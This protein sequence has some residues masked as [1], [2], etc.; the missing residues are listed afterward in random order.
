M[1]YSDFTRMLRYEMTGQVTFWDGQSYDTK[2]SIYK[3][4]K[5]WRRHPECVEESQIS[6]DL[7]DGGDFLDIGAFRGYY[8]ALLAPKAKPGTHF[9][10]VEPDPKALPKLAGN[11][12]GLAKTFPHIKFSVINTACGIGRVVSVTDQNGHPCYASADEEEQGVLAATVDSLCLGLGLSPSFVKVDVEGAESAVL[13]G[14]QKTLLEAEKWM[15]EIHPDWLPEGVN[16]ADVEA[17]FTANGYTQKHIQNRGDQPLIW[18][19]K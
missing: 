10:S 17:L 1:R 14:A 11:L 9:V 16:A 3:L 13:Q 5:H 2:R 12:A 8:S 18:Y 7:Y 19:G 6:F 4:F 15:I